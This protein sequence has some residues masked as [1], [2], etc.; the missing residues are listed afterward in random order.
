MIWNETF[1]P[2][3][4]HIT[5]ET[6]TLRRA[7]RRTWREIIYTHDRFKSREKPPIALQICHESRALALKHYTPSFHSRTTPFSRASEVKQTALY[8]NP[9][10]DTIHV[11]DDV[12]ATMLSHPIYTE[13]TKRIKTLAIAAPC[14]TIFAQYTCVYT[15]SRVLPALERLETYILVIEGGEAESSTRK[16]M[17]DMMIQAQDRLRLEGKCGE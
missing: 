16:N 8:F 17:E 11:V 1:E 5:Q 7:T 9:E 6:T 15:L 2:R 14:S 12:I 3:I 4:L 10:L 13:T